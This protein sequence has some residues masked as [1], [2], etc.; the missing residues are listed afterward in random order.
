M[1]AL[2]AIYP[3]LA[4]YI[5]GSSRL[6]GIFEFCGCIYSAGATYKELPV[7]L[8]IQVNEGL[9]AKEALLEPVSP[10]H[11]GLLRFCKESLQFA[12]L[13]LLI[14]KGSHLRS[15]SNAAICAK[16]SIGSNHPAI[17]NNIFYRVFGKVVLH[18]GVL[19]A[20]HIG[21]ALKHNC[22]CPLVAWGC[23]CLYK[24]IANLVHLALKRVLLCPFAQI[25]YYLLFF[26]ALARN[27]CNLIKDFQYFLLF[28]ISSKIISQINLQI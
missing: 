7:I 2:A 16:G 27:L 15:H 22:I 3:K 9:A 12:V 5:I 23:R 11:S 26:A 28:H 1:S 13:K 6:C 4:F 21:V 24:H 25:C 14:Y 18:A 8:G 17:L 10:I 20:H 19:L